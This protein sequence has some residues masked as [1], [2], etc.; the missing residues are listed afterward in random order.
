[1][2]ITRLGPNQDITAAKIAGQINFKNIIING[3]MSIAQRGAGPSGTFA[4]SGFSEGPDRYEHILIGLGT[5]QSSQSTDVPSGQG[6]SSSFRMNCISANA[7]AASNDNIY[8]RQKIEAQNLQH[9]KYGTSSAES[10]TLSFWVKSTKTGTFVV[11]LYQDD[12]TRSVAKSYTVNSSDTWEKKTITFDGDTTG[13]IDNDNGSGIRVNFFLGAGTDWTSGTLATSW[14]A[15]TK[16]NRAVGQVNC[17]DSTSN[18]WYITG[19]QLEVGT[20][21]SDFEFLPYD[22]NLQRC[23][24]YYYYIGGTNATYK[25]IATVITNPNNRNQTAGLHALPVPM[26]GNPTVSLP[27]ASN[28]TGVYIGGADN[29]GSVTASGQSEWS[30][31]KDVSLL[32]FSGTL[33]SNVGNHALQAEIS[34]NSTYKLEADAEL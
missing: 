5:W 33:Q 15:D 14:E 12:D 18:N 4:G 6:F 31:D 30:G 28:I 20:T 17:A 34:Y 9:L 22:V 10:L 1:M 3:D 2:A 27:S 32:R 29:Y 7:S 26:R 11:W 8:V 16:A 19:V 21:A 23:Q 25:R 24:R 13:I